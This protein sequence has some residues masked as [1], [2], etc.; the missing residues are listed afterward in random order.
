M[1]NRWSE[2]EASSLG[3]LGRIAYV[4]R[5]M[6][7]EHDLV[8]WGGGNTSLKAA[9]RDAFGRSCRILWMKPSGASLAGIQPRDFSALQLDDLSTLEDRK[10]LDDAEM[11][12]L[13]TSALIDPEDARPR[14]AHDSYP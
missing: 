11:R 6:G 7:R 2:T 8:L 14:L 12:K 9:G 1:E 10:A 4:S 13:V 5:L 3:D